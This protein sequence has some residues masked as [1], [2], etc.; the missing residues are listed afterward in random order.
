YRVKAALPLNALGSFARITFRRGGGGVIGPEGEDEEERGGVMSLAMVL[1]TR[2]K[3]PKDMEEASGAWTCVEGEC[4]GACKGKRDGCRFC[5]ERRDG[6]EADERHRPE[7]S[8]MPKNGLDGEESFEGIM[9]VYGGGAD[10]LHERNL[11]AGR[12][13]Y[14]L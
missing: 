4:D 5:E 6:D 3:S 14:V 12:R 1:P 8:F 9:D 7:K 11:S 13:A 10:L 2:E